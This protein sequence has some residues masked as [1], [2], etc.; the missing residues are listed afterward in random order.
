MGGFGRKL[1]CEAEGEGDEHHTSATGAEEWERDACEG[2]EVDHGHDVDEDVGGDPAEDTDDDE[3]TGGVVE[4]LREAEESVEEDREKY[5]DEH[6]PDEAESFAHDGED[7]VAGGFGEVAGGLDAIADADTEES[8]RADG[9][10]RMHD[11]V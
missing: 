8:A 5:Q 4:V 6:K 7:G 2:D 10:A 1:E 11:V 9:D 3:T